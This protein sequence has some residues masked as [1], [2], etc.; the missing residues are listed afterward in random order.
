M[1]AKTI[2]DYSDHKLKTMSMSKSAQKRRLKNL[3]KFIGSLQAN[4]HDPLSRSTASL[5]ANLYLTL[6][7]D[8]VPILYRLRKKRGERA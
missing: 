1:T 5:A 6:K 7:Y 8:H 4:R 2:L 3:S